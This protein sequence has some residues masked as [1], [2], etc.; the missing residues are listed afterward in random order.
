MRSF[1][2]LLAAKNASVNAAAKP[3]SFDELLAAKQA[4]AAPVERKFGRF[5]GERP[6]ATENQPSEFTTGEQLTD[7]GRTIGRTNQE[8]SEF[9]ADMAGFVIPNYDPATGNISSGFSERFRSGMGRAGE[10]EGW[11]LSKIGAF[12]KGFMEPTEYGKRTAKMFESPEFFDE[13][14]AEGEGDMWLDPLKKGAQLTTELGTTAWMGGPKG[15][16]AAMR[17]LPLSVTAGAAGEQVAG[18]KGELAGVMGAAFAQDYPAMFKLLT[19]TGG[20]LTSIPRKLKRSVLSGDTVANASDNEIRQG[21]EEIIRNTW[22]SDPELMVSH[23]DEVFKRVKTKIAAGEKGTLG[24]LSGDAGILDFEKTYAKEHRRSDVQRISG[25]IE[26]DVYD[27]T[28]AIEGDAAQAARVPAKV[29]A[30]EKQALQEAAQGVLTK[31]TTA[32]RKAKR[33]AARSRPTTEVSSDLKKTTQKIKDDRFAVAKQAFDDIPNEGGKIDAT[34]ITAAKKKYWGDIEDPHLQAEFESQFPETM[35]SLARIEKE[36]GDVSLEALNAVLSKYS[37]ESVGTSMKPKMVDDFKESIYGVLDNIEGASEA[38]KAAAKIYRDYQTDFGARSQT[39]KALKQADE[40][41]ADVVTKTKG[42][43]AGTRAEQSRVTA[44][45][46]DELSDESLRSKFNAEHIDQVTG[47]LKPNAVKTF[48][49]QYG[50]QMSPE[51][52]KEFDKM[53]K[54]G[55][56]LEEAKKGMTEAEKQVAAIDKSGAGRFASTG[57]EQREI[58]KAA[59][60]I[61]STATGKNV[62]KKIEELLKTV[63]KADP[64]AK[65]HIQRAFMDDFENVIT[66]KKGDFK[67]DSESLKEFRARRGAYEKS[68]LFT[69]KQLDTLEDSLVEGQKIYLHEFGPALAKL[70]P[71][72]KRVAEVLAALAGA[73]VGAMAFGSPLI[74]AALGRRYA[75]KQLRAMGTDKARKIAFELTM[76]PEK[77]ADIITKLNKHDISDAAIALNIKELFKRAA[78]GGRAEVIG[79][80]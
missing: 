4:S 66:T 10:D 76:N 40:A 6:A 58:V 16:E 73:K 30:D 1:E 7:V 25:Q 71:P 39:G 79:D 11:G 67:L 38:R 61:M 29:V 63:E 75:T 19:K 56:S 59:E 42:R 54:T 70:P 48:Q 51:L 5:S 78:M 2:E 14:I 36:G 65:Q 35:K 8:T 80:E 28:G 21:L 12:G 52:T 26:Q 60:D 62:T 64:S 3:R 77:F 43:G 50:D 46:T 15:V 55:I 45:A 68:G 69:T 27:A 22:T 47:E 23:I 57:P 24:Q 18:G 31:T 13:Q 53:R 37:A 17:T 41:Y 9:M 33:T 32:E 20:S 44:G 34:D 72:E 74:G 49:K